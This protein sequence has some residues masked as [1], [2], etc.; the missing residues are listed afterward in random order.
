MKL[1]SPRPA[2]N[3][4]GAELALMFEREDFADPER[5]HIPGKLNICSDFLSRVM[6]DEPPPRPQALEGVKIRILGKR[7]EFSL[8]GFGPGIRPDLWGSSEARGAQETPQASPVADQELASVGADSSGA[9]P[10]ASSSWQ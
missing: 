8:K 3:F 2:M 1:A 10:A 9:V 5:E 4:V 7:R 6:T